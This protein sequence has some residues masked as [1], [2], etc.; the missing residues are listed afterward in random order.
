MVDNVQ[1]RNFSH[2]IMFHHFHDAVHPASQGSISSHELEAMIEWLSTR[3]SILD[4]QEYGDRLQQST[5]RESDICLTFDDALLCQIDVAVPVL[6]RYG[7]SAF[8][9]VY[10]SPLCGEANPLELYRFV[11]TVTFANVDLF[12][13]QFFDET[14]SALESQYE[15]A[16]SSYDGSSYLKDFP[17]YTENDKWF[18]FVRDRVLG[19][20]RY[21]CVMQN[22]MAKHDFNRA[23]ASQK[24][25]MNDQHVKALRAQGHV[26]GLHSYSHPMVM[27]QLGVE[28]QEW[29]YRSNFDHLHAVLGHAPHAMSHPCGSYNSSTLD[30]LRSMGI[31]VGFRSNTSISQMRS[32]LEVPR[33]DHANILRE[34]SR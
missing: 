20:E 15:D 18:R 34:M 8:F 29:E 25:W 28:Q 11:R 19:Q 2:A 14:H 10:S 23:A 21:D 22:L 5:L 27:D 9:F 24:L 3:H 13:D 17:F 30:I 16:K 1:K 4:A 33:E 12:Y 26:I 6:A 7:I 31:T 32:A